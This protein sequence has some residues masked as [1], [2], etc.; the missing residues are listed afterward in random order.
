MRD[1]LLKTLEGLYAITGQMQFETLLRLPEDECIEKVN[2]LLDELVKVWNMFHFISDERKRQIIHKHI[3][4]DKDFRGMYPNKLAQWFHDEWDSY[5][6][7]KKQKIIQSY[8]EK[9]GLENDKQKQE[10]PV[11]PEKAQEY[12]DQLRNQVKGAREP[13]R[14]TPSGRMKRYR[15]EASATTQGLVRRI[16]C[17]RCDNDVEKRKDCDYC[18]GKGTILTNRTQ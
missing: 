4:A 11:D 15:L 18:S 8:Y 6:A 10:S 9:K 2:L 14:I 12:I 13:R 16:Q 3:L 1:F 5:N 17:P 7:A